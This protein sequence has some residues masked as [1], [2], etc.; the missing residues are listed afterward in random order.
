MKLTKL[1]P[2]S[3]GFSLVELMVSIT[4]MAVIFG[5]SAQVLVSARRLQEVVTGKNALVDMIRE[6]KNVSLSPSS[7][8]DPARVVGI[9]L[10]RPQTAR[11]VSYVHCRGIS[12]SDPCNPITIKDRSSEIFGGHIRISEIKFRDESDGT[13]HPIPGGS[14]DVNIFYSIPFGRACI[15]SQL[16]ANDTAPDNIGETIG[17]VNNIYPVNSSLG[18][19]RFARCDDTPGSESDVN[20]Q[21]HS[22][23]YITL[24]Y[25]NFPN[26]S[27]T[28]RVNTYSGD[29]SDV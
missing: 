9:Y 4:I 21:L 24:N 7:S 29:V 5:L 2:D 19:S 17:E 23:L 13:D 20:K 3:P 27:Q 26:I 14:Q 18:A 10:N 11:L 1:K 12:Y 25:D 8:A 22:F 15:T 16:D 6:A 28:I